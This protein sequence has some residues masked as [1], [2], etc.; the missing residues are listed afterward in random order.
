MGKT[1]RGRQRD[2]KTTK[3]LRERRDRRRKAKDADNHKKNDLS[4]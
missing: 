1:I 4:Y 3:K 2:K